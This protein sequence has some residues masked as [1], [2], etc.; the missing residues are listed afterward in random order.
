[1]PG[2]VLMALVLLLPPSVLS[3]GKA[4]DIVD[5]TDEKAD[6]LVKGGW[7]RRLYDERANTVAA[8]AAASAKA[9]REEAE[10]FAGNIRD[11]GA[12]EQAIIESFAH[13]ITDVD[14]RP[15]TMPD[16]TPE[17]ALMANPEHVEALKRGVAQAKAG[18]FVVYDLSIDDDL[19]MTREEAMAEAAANDGFDDDGN[20]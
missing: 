2:G 9:H 14:T 5:V 13:P 1:M 12:M 18:D 20:G 11:S 16:V 15:T 17:E 19:G 4:G 3:I 8:K 7:G 6:S 10:R